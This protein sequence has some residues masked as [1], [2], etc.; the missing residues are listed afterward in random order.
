VVKVNAPFGRHDDAPLVYYKWV[1]FN[2]NK[3]CCQ[4]KKSKLE[5]HL[6]N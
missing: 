5:F 6:I 3:E 2:L 4:K 1:K